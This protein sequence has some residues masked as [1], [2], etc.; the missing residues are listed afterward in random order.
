MVSPGLAALTMPHQALLVFTT[1]V[2]PM[3]FAAA[4]PRGEEDEDGAGTRFHRRI[5]EARILF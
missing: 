5:V 4:R 3:A 2:L 1:I